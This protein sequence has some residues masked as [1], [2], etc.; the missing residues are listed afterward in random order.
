M[1]EQNFHSKSCRRFQTYARF[2]VGY[3]FLVI[4]WGAWVR[5]S[6]S[7]DGCGDHWP[8]CQGALIPEFQ[9]KKTWI[10][11]AHRAMS[12]IF[13]ILILF[14]FLW[15]RSL[16]KQIPSKKLLRLFLTA[17]AIFT[18]TEALL[19]AQLVLKGLVGMD[20]SF[21]R[22]FFMG[23]H[24][25]NSLCLSG[26]IAMVAYL[27][28]AKSELRFQWK[29]QSIF[30]GFL[31]FLLMI[32]SFG[33][34]ASLSTTLFPHSNIFE[35]LQQEFSDSKN[36]IL[37]WRSL[38]PV[39]AVLGSFLF[40]SLFRWKS[41]ESDLKN[42]KQLRRMILVLACAI[43][44]GVLTLLFQSPLLLKLLHLSF[45]HGI[46]ILALQFLFLEKTSNKKTLG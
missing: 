39:F 23:L 2:L 10:E 5:I 29:T 24:M 3:T 7:G 19:G 42:P 9:Q 46:W 40:L 13:G 6:H 1:G 11:Y 41:S 43:T 45:A 17:S 20:A 8:L 26:S 18:L 15:G 35:S 14:L 38:H 22:S 33:S 44:V 30:V 32:S 36:W 37:T 12:G 28:A 25:V 16:S 27:A 34:V 21:D 31:L 4:L